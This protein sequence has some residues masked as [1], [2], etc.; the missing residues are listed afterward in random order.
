M[1]K[2]HTLLY[3]IIYHSNVSSEPKYISA[4]LVYIEISKSPVRPRS[5][6]GPVGPRSR[7]G[8]V[9]FEGIF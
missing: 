4:T 2:I 9:P 8:L 7:G 1:K 3:N 5:C 6:G